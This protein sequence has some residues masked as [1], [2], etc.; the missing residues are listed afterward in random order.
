MTPPDPADLVDPVSVIGLV[1]LAQPDQYQLAV[2]IGLA[3]IE[4]RR[5]AAMGALRDLLLGTG[6][7]A[8]EQGQMDTLDLLADRRGWRMGDLADAL[9]V[10]PSSATR[11][12]QRLVNDGLADRRASDDDGR[13]VLVFIT[14]GGRR[15]HAE[16]AARRGDMMKHLLGAFEP[17]ERPL[18]AEL[19]ERFVA[20]VDDYVLQVTGTD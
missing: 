4:I 2:R 19:L 9:R 1:D 5:G 15:R 13:V 17:H 6:D 8:L 16:V 14:D 3:W 12:V 10:D 18:L 11:A 20:S 7:D